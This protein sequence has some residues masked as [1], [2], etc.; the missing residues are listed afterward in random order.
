MSKP[1]MMYFESMCTRCR[2]CIDVCPPRAITVQADGAIVTDRQVCDACGRCAEECPNRARVITGKVMNVAEVLD[3]VRKDFLFYVNSGGGVTASGGEPLHQY[4]FVAEV[5]RRCEEHAIHTAVETSG[6]GPWHALESILPVT[7]LFLYDVKQMDPEKHRRLTG[8]DNHLILDNLRKLVGTGK[9]VV[10]RF[11]LIPDRND[12]PDNIAALARLAVG[13]G[14]KDIDI[15]PYH[16]L[17][18][19]KYER[20]GRT[21]EL[22]GVP[23]YDPNRAEVVRQTL[24]SYGLNVGLL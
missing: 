23:Q 17:G 15:V 7:S 5:F 3:V 16:R 12:E 9:P 13:L 22:A 19:K 10:L 1:E 2:R 18:D 4:E 24:E 11:P 6:Y 8:V 21:Y 20:L 14:L